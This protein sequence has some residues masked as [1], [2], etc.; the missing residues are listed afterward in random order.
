MIAA[1]RLAGAL[2]LAIPAAAPAMPVDS[3]YGSDAYDARLTGFSDTITTN[4]PVDAVNNVADSVA[5]SVNAQIAQAQGAVDRSL[6]AQ[7]QAALQRTA[8]R[9]HTIKAAKADLRNQVRSQ[10]ARGRADGLTARQSFERARTNPG[11][12]RL[13]GQIQSQDKASR[14]AFKASSERVRD[15][16][17]GLDQ[18]R[19][20]TKRIVQNVG[21]LRKLTA[22]LGVVDWASSG[23]RTAGYAWN[24]AFDGGDWES[25]RL[26]A[27]EEVARKQAAAQGGAAGSAAGAWAGSFAGPKGMAV[28]GALGA[29]SGAYGATVAF[30]DNVVPALERK[31]R[32]AADRHAIKKWGGGEDALRRSGQHRLEKIQAAVADGD[33]EKAKRLHAQL[34]SSIDLYREKR[35]EDAALFDLVVKSSDMSSA[36]RKSKEAEYARQEQEAVAYQED[37]LAVR[38]QLRTEYDRE[39]AALKELARTGP[40]SVLQRPEKRQLKAGDTIA[41]DIQ[42]SGGQP[43]YRIAGEANATVGAH[44]RVAYKVT[45]PAEPGIYALAIQVTDANGRQTSN[46]TTIRVTGVMV[47]SGRWSGRC[48]D[49]FSD[50]KRIKVSGSFRATV[51][52]SGGLSGSYGGSDSGS[53]GG[54]VGVDGAFSASAGQA[55]ACSWSGSTRT[56]DGRLTGRGSWTCEGDCRGSWSSN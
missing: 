11:I 53:I 5:S 37:R 16:R 15:A 32:E 44:D 8:Q 4:G 34:K 21:Y 47:L 40:Y 28:G 18:R 20:G 55:G 7:G 42:V 36:I 10:Y 9:T 51:N 49:Y 30:D 46:E 24:A 3:A 35:G 43:P 25:V 19:Q 33:H 12:Q 48:A 52:E 38:E 31:R 45:A 56:R 41:V 14:A 1:N 39:Q 54:S 23:L 2:L 13:S 6:N 27:S 26:V 17:R 50:G 22:G 29:F